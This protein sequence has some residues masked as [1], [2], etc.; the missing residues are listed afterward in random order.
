MDRID[1]RVLFLQKMKLSSERLGHLP[2]H[3]ANEKC[4]KLSPW[5]SSLPD[6]GGKKEHRW[7]NANMNA[8]ELPK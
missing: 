7:K 8:Y 5:N 1:I 2:G 6:D 3:T 4:Q